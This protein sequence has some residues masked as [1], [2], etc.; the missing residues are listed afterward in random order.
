MVLSIVLTVLGLGM[1]CV[2]IF[3]LAVYALPA[4]VGLSAMFW[5]IG[6]GA[7]IASVAIGLIAGIGMFIAGQAT[8]SISSAP[9]VRW[10]V[11][12]IFA[13]PAA[14]AGYSLILQLSSIGNPSPLWQ[15]AFAI[16]GAAVIGVTA[17]I[18]LADVRRSA[19]SPSRLHMQVN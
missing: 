9:W 5:A 10:M 14:Y 15:H 12:M 13:G 19:P 3:R 17:L 11:A 18:R 16:A 2:L 6:A 7:E 4:F 8:F 1:L